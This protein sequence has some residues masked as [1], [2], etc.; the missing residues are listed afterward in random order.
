MS[1]LAD[2]VAYVKSTAPAGGTVPGGG[3][4]PSRTLGSDVYNPGDRSWGLI[5]SNRSLQSSGHSAGAIRRWT[6]YE[7]YEGWTDRDNTIT[8]D[9][10]DHDIHVKFQISARIR[11]HP[12]DDPDNERYVVQIRVWGESTGLGGGVDADVE[13]ARAIWD[14]CRLF[15]GMDFVA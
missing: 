5:S 1:A 3:G 7:D 8:H 13:D 4:N 2:F 11:G 10:K 9:E 12:K 6:K 14:D 15:A